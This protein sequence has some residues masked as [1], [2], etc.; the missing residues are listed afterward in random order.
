MVGTTWVAVG[1][2]A[3]RAGALARV[4]ATVSHRDRSRGQSRVVVVVLLCLPDRHN[5]WAVGGC[6]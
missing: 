5:L 1:M 2:T 6:Q 4:G 3:K